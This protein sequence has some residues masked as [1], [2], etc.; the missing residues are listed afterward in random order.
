MN[1]ILGPNRAGLGAVC[2][3]L[4]IKVGCGWQ[5]KSILIELG[6]I[7]KKGVA[8]YAVVLSSQT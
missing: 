8:S 6:E 7:L 4:R 5:D 1:G 3:P 2:A